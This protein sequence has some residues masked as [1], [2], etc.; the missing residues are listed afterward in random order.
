MATSTSVNPFKVHTAV[1]I[2]GMALSSD[3][4]D[5]YLIDSGKLITFP[6]DTSSGLVIGEIFGRLSFAAQLRSS[7]NGQATPEETSN[8][9]PSETTEDEVV[10][11]A[12][13]ASAVGSNNVILPTKN[14]VWSVQYVPSDR[15]F[16]IIGATDL[17]AFIKGGN[18]DKKPE[19]VNPIILIVNTIGNRIVLKRNLDQLTISAND[20]FVSKDQVLS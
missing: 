12:V 16:S 1:R 6:M 5:F 4:K 15:V 7:G 17:D 18:P 8:D 3:F 19:D 11:R 9:D 2:D 10:I 14:T 13:S 20:I